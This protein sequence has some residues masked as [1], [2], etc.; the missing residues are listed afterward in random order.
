MIAGKS[1]AN[2]P[3]AD[4]VGTDPMSLGEAPLYEASS[5]P[6]GQCRI[7]CQWPA[8]AAARSRAASVFFV[9]VAARSVVYIVCHFGLRTD[10]CSSSASLSGLRPGPWSTSS[11]LRPPPGGDLCNT[12]A[13]G[14][15]LQIPY[16]Y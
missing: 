6:H 12:T 8:G 3:V 4:Q 16:A 15:A 11:G 9:W 10:P 2:V 14:I 7:A 5:M 1:S 13:V